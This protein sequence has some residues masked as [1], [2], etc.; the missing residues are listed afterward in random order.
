MDGGNDKK[1]FWQIKTLKKCLKGTTKKCL[2]AFYLRNV[3]CHVL[4]VQSILKYIDFRF[5]ITCINYLV[6]NS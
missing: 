6:I 2:T 1:H 5:P 3:C 4:D